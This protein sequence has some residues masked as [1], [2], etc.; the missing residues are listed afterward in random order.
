LRCQLD[1]HGVW[2]AVESST[3]KLALDR[4]RTPLLRVDYVRG[5]N[6]A[7]CAHLQVHAH[8]GALTHLLSQAGHAKA[9]DMSA[10]HLPLGGARFR[11]CLEDVLQ[12]L[13]DEC[14]VESVPGWRDAVLAG[15]ARWRRR[16]ARTVTRDFLEEAADV[17]RSEG[18]RVE[19]PD[20]VPEISGKALYDW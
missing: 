1:S 17:L 4:D 14:Q 2:L 16:Q 10:L 9:H 15:R 19:P 7:P 6:K 18:Y 11:P 3:Y 12:F 13:V 20:E 8:R 5:A